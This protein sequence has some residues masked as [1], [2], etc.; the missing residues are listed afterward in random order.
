LIYE[1]GWQVF[2]QKMII[3]CIIKKSKGSVSALRVFIIIVCLR[4][5]IKLLDIS[6]GHSIVISNAMKYLLTMISPGCLLIYEEMISPLLMIIFA[7]I[8]L[9][10]F[11][12][13]LFL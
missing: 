12:L 1:R 7:E 8:F 4:V 10:S 5:L 6:K 3:L 2:N 9:V 11:L 13:R